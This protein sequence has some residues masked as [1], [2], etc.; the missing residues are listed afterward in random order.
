MEIALVG[1]LAKKVRENIWFNLACRGDKVLVGGFL[2]LRGKV[3][4]Y[5]VLQKLQITKLS[6]DFAFHFLVLINSISFSVPNSF[7]L[8]F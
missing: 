7:L 2:S 8:Q 4:T 5:S 6:L 1:H 3:G